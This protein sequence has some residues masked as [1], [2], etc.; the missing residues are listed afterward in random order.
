MYISSYGKRDFIS[1]VLE[2]GARRSLKNNASK[3]YS[4]HRQFSCKKSRKDKNRVKNDSSDEEFEWG[5]QKYPTQRRPLLPSKDLTHTGDENAYDHDG[6][7]IDESV[8]L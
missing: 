4:R 8:G 5:P 2:N 3:D 6:V 7:E 1:P